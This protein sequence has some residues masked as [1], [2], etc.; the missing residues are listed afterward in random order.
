M[1]VNIFNP[2]CKVTEYSDDLAHGNKTE[3]RHID[4]IMSGI[5][6]L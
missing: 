6:M 1:L 3:L 5:G 2:K 4:L